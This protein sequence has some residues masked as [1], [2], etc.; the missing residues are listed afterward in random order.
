MISKDNSEFVSFS[1]LN[2]MTAKN[3]DRRLVCARSRL[4]AACVRCCD[5]IFTLPLKS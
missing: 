2:V 4:Q 1:A 5:V 3:L